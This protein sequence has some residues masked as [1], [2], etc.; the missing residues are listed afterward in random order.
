[1]TTDLSLHREHFAAD[2]NA[3]TSFELLEEA[4]VAGE[5]WQT[6]AD[7][8]R[9]RASASSLADDPAARARLLLQLGQLLEERIRD[10]DA[11]IE[12]YRDC[13]RLDAGCRASW[14]GLRRLYAARNSW[15]AVL[16]VA[17]LEAGSLD[18]P[19]ERARLLQ[20]MGQIWRDQLGDAEQAEQYFQRARQERDSAGTAP[21]PEPDAERHAALVQEAW[22]CAARG[23]SIR[24]VAALR[25]ALESDPSNVEAI[26]MLVTVL[27]GAERHAELAELLERR[28][29]LAADPTTRA[30]VLSRLGQV[31]E[32]QL[33][34]MSGARSAYERALDSDPRS[35]GARAALLRIYRLTESWNELR[36]LLETVGTE[37]PLEQRVETLCQLGLLLERQFDDVEAAVASFEEALALEPDNPDAKAALTRLRDA[38]AAVAAGQKEESQA[39]GENRAVRVVSVLERK[40]ERLESEGDGAS[41]AATQLRMRL[42]E[43]RSTKLDDPIGAIE[44]LEPCVE[45]EEALL[46]V[47]QRLALLYERSGRHDALIGLSRR[48]AAVSTDP[49][50]RAEWFRR[51]A[52]TARSI[53]A[54]D[55]AVELFGRLLEERP[56]DRHA[57]TALI[58]LHRTR[59]NAEPLAMMLRHEL[60]RAGRHDELP[61]QVELAQ[62][63][64]EALGRDL[65][66]LSHWRRALAL[67]PSREDTLDDGL[68][69]ANSTGGALHQL[70][71]LD[72]AAAAA[73][74]RE[75]RARL[76]LR[77][78]DLLAQDLG[79]AEEALESWRRALELDP[80]RADARA[81]LEGAGS[82]A[83]TP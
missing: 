70:E 63:L 24:A 3:T 59:G 65:D 74:A 33:G 82:T 53:G 38:S 22:I 35:Q 50:E 54:G 52:E 71:L 21:A 20:E 68:R 16:Q 56:R 83:A 73:T 48:A 7:L 9:R 64:S 37:T 31:R 26:D 36:R 29:A 76:L 42:A 41:E 5:Q 28:A 78:G 43:L 80:S 32:E 2:P 51:A 30:A 1:M 18:D 79:W 27:D 14:Q 77:R 46:L 23:D 49:V 39:S 34:D 47:A 69:C 19:S 72:H 75:D 44:V 13:A 45:R 10:A 81:R 15:A 4:A 12:A 17:E 25:E 11:A 61:I 67:D 6:L 62:L 55:V 40:L 66:A 8:Y 58:D 60:S 57:E